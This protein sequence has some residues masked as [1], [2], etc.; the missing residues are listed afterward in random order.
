MIET[1][2]T[3]LPYS[4]HEFVMQTADG[5]YMIYIN[6]KLSYL[7][8]RRAYDHAV[9]HIRNHDFDADQTADEIERR[10]HDVD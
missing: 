6:Q 7:A 3:N 9:R 10:C 8:Q 4:I 2:L 1:R 5:D